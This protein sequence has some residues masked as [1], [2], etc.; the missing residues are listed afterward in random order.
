M[1]ATCMS[2]PDAPPLPDLIANIKKK[3][4]HQRQAKW[5][6]RACAASDGV[7]VCLFTGWALN[8]APEL[9]AFVVVFLLLAWWMLR[10]AER[11][12]YKADHTAYHLRVTEAL[13]ISGAQ[14]DQQE[15]HANDS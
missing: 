15:S 3:L 12:A 2:N 13:L 8:G 10:S 4:R 11:L 1:C 7:L 9:G 14:V 6:A 5:L